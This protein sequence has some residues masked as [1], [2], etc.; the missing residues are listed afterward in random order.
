MD[1]LGWTEQMLALPPGPHPSLTGLGDVMVS[2]QWG[3]KPHFETW[4]EQGQ[5]VFS[6]PSLALTWVPLLPTLVRTQCAPGAMES[7]T[8]L[9]K[10]CTSYW[11]CGFS[12]LASQLWASVTSLYSGAEG[13]S[14]LICSA[15][16]RST[17]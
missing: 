17:L 7:G 6:H 2:G 3:H 12:K 16:A 9:K 14:C 15:W 8:S 13:C 11:L 10:S 5:T 4:K 1:V